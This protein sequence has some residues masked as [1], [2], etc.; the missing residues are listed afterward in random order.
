MKLKQMDKQKRCIVRAIQTQD[1]KW[2]DI[3]DT[4]QLE[5]DVS[6]CQWMG[7]KDIIIAADCNKRKKTRDG[8]EVKETKAYADDI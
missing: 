8:S 7:T 3:K 5:K 6:E 2:T 1:I 4:C